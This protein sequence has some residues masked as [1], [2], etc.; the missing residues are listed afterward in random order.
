MSDYLWETGGRHRRH[1]LGGAR[2]GPPATGSCTSTSTSSWPRSRCCGAPSWPGRPVIVG[3]DGDPTRPRQVVATASYEARAFGV[4]SGMP[5]RTAARRCPDAVFLPTDR[6]GLRRGVG[7]GHGHA[8]LVPGGGRGVGL[9]RGVRRRHHRRSRGAGP[10]AS[11]P[12][13]STATRLSCAV[14]IGETRLQA[15]TATGFAKP[16]GVARL[17]RATWLPTMGDRPVTAIWGIGDR[18]ARRL[19]EAGVHTVHDLAWADH[20][21]LARRFGPA[22]RPVAAGARPRRRPRAGRGRAVGAPV[23]QQG[24]DLPTRPHR[25]GRGP[26]R[27]GAPRRR[28]DRLG[29]RRG[30]HRDPRRTSRSAPPRSS[31]ASSPRSCPSRRPTP[32]WW[33]SGRWSCST[34]SSPPGASACWACG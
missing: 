4:R 32:T 27:G 31:P 20:E 19:A 9:G 16:G 2:A 30:P 33:P 10:R 5:L 8:A 11:R 12:G 26:R 21:D 7:R 13:C 18:T 24:D 17:T 28:G 15:K 23:A 3:G 6:A 14:G 34:A 29:R 22:H 25:P 1:A